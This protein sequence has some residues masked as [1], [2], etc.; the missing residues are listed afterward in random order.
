MA[1]ESTMEIEERKL[2]L[3]DKLAAVRLLERMADDVTGV[4]VVIPAG[5]IVQLDGTTTVLG[6]MLEI[7]WNGAR[8]GVFSDDLRRR[9][10]KLKTVVDY[11]PSE[12][13]PR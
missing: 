1:N 8:Y 13:A 11:L 9:S 2:K 4:A 7:E 10:G 3:D 6:R 5:E 12:I